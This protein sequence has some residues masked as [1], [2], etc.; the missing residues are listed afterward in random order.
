MTP[1]M[2]KESQNGLFPLLPLTH[3]KQ[4]RNLDI[5]KYLYLS[6]SFSVPSFSSISL[7]FTLL[8]SVYFSVYSSTYLELPS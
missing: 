6:P 5:Y 2:S 1:M 4:S 7:K 8:S 3:S